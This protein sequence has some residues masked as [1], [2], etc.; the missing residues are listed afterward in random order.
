MLSLRQGRSLHP[1]HELRHVREPQ[2]LCFPEEEEVPE[3]KSHLEL[4]TF[5]YTLLRFALGPDH[6]VGFGPVRLLERVRPAPLL[7]ARRVRE[8]W[9]PGP[10]VWIVENLGAARSA[11]SRR[12][13]Y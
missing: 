13:D 1:S 7:V 6:S 4:R 9:R 8:A 11:G 2:P 12:R 10:V 5:L 3:G